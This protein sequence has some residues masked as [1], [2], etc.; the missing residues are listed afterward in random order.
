MT[1][2]PVY[3][4]VKGLC[5]HFPQHNGATRGQ[6]K[7]LDNIYLEMERGEALSILG[8]NGSGKSTFLLVLAGLVKPE[9]GEVTI[10]GNPPELA[11][12]NGEIGYLPQDFSTSLYPWR[13]AIDNIAFPLEIKGESKQ[14]RHDV[15][16]QLLTELDLGLSHEELSRFP[17]QLSGGQQ[18]RVALA[19]ALILNPKLIILDEPFSAIFPEDKLALRDK[20][21]RIRKKLALTMILVSQDIEESCY[22]GDRIALFSRRPAKIEKVFAI[23]GER[24]LNILTSKDFLG[25]KCAIETWFKMGCTQ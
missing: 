10:G 18:Q 16:D 7:V 15:V 2:D 8:W 4:I 6:V 13:T 9:A 5:H 19:R 11:L 20:L 12:R 23:P 17:Y 24:S 21:L 3:L 22:L 25:I 1:P 14:K